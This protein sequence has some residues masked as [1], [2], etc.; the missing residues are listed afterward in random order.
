MANRFIEFASAGY[1]GHAVNAEA[2]LDAEAVSGGDRWIRDILFLATFLLT[3]FTASPFPDLG[4]Q[5]LLDPQTGGDLFGQVSAVTLTGALAAFVFVKRSPLVPRMVT[6]PLVL[7]LAAFAISAALSSYPDVALRRLLLTALTIFQATAILLLPYGRE[8]FA[9]L[10]AIGAII[11]LGA[12]YTGVALFPQYS[13]HQAS[14]I[15]EPGLAG[16]WRGFFTHKNG[17]G[18]AMVVLIFIGIF[19]CR[20]WDR[21]TGI[22]IIV[23]AGVFLEF[24][25]SKSPRNLLPLVLALSYLIPRMRSSLL[26]LGL[27]LAV[28]IAINILTI[29][30]VMFAPIG[31]LINATLSDPTY[32][33][34]DVIWSFALDHV[35]ARPLFGFGY[36]SFWRMPN[37]VADW[38]YLDSWGYRASDAHNGYLNL[39]VTTG[40]VGLS[41]SLCWMVGQAFAD[42]RRAQAQGADP[43]LTALFLQILIFGLCLGGFESVFFGGGD[44][45]WFLMVTSIAGMRFQ[46]VA[47]TS[48]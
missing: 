28:P 8:H 26:A 19:V 38:S 39:A 48:A 40:L 1:R 37:L 42:Y 11:V 47:K 45:L 44:C 6:L 32:D 16:D 10:L 25:Q 18:A 20:S 27:I 30:S 7:T 3:W 17:A 35:A 9:R 23:L 43:A 36:E 31:N 4:D 24:T 34:R 2:R 33:G 5:H 13:V 21:F 15:A 29:G 22:L 12:C 46:S 41:L 14:D